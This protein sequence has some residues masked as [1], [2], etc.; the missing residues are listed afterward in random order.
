MKESDIQCILEVGTERYPEVTP[1]IISDNGPQFIAEEFK[2]YIRIKGM[3]HVRTSPFYPQSNGQV[4]RFH[5]N[6]KRECIQ[7]QT[8]LDLDDAQRIIQKYVDFYNSERLHAVIGYVTPDDHL[9]GRTK[10]IHAA[11]DQKRA[12]ARERRKH[13]SQNKHAA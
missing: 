8:P 2:T 1:R 3:D 10:A 12:Q 7:P 11:R 9:H 6:I 13:Y 5:H 4:E